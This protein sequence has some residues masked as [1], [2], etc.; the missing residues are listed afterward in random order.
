MFGVVQNGMM[1][2]P[3]VG[4]ALLHGGHLMM[5]RILKWHYVWFVRC[6]IGDRESNFPYNQISDNSF[7]QNRQNG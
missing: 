2:D 5:W 3:V 1:G 7:C 6:G 4:Y